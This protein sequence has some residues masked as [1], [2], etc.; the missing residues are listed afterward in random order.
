[1]YFLHYLSKPTA[2]HNNM[3]DSS[4]F[5]LNTS[6]I[7]SYK[8]SAIAFSSAVKMFDETSSALLIG[9]QL[10]SVGQ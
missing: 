5:C 6:K 8:S 10:T 9:R 4:V 3:G 7:F 1:M 2:L